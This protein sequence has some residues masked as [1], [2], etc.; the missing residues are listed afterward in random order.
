MRNLKIFAM[1]V[2]FVLALGISASAQVTV[3]GSTGANGSYANLG[4]AFTAI[5]GATQTGNN[6]TV[7]IT[8]NVTE[9]GPAVLNSGAW[10][11]LTI[12]PTADLLTISGATATGRGLIE[13]N[14]ADNVTIDGDN[15]GSGGTNRNLTI[16][17]TAA[18]TITY[19]SVIRLAVLASTQTS[20]DNVTIKNTILLGS[21]TGRNAVANTSTTGSE[22]TVFGIYAGGNGGATVPTAITSVTTNTAPSGTTVNNFNVTNNSINACARGV[23]FN[24]AA[25]S[26]SNGVTVSGNTIGD[27]STPTPATPPYTSPA[28]T[29]YTKGIW[30]AGAGAVTVTGNTINDVI[31]YVGTTISA[32][33]LNSVIGTSVTISSNTVTNTANNGTVSIVKAILVSSATGTY[34]IA[35]NIVTNVQAVAGTS[36]TS[37]IEVTSASLTGSVIERNKITTVYNRKDD[38]WGAWGLNLTGGTGITVRNN[39][40]SDLQSATGGSGTFSTTFGIFGLRIAGGTNHK[41]YHNSVNLFGPLLVGTGTNGTLTAAFAVT[42]TTVTGMDVRNNI[43]ANTLTSGNASTAHVSMFL[44]SSATSSMNLTINNNDYFSG[45]T[46]GQSG[47]AHVGTTYTAVPAGPATYAGLY[48]AANFNPADTANVLNLRTYTNT[49]NG[50]GTNDNASKVVDPLFVS[51]TDL[52]IAVAS[53]MV[54]MGAS[55]GVTNDIDSQLRVA[56]PDIGADEPSGI[57]PPANDIAA[58]AIL[59]PAPSSLVTTGTAPTPQASFTNAGTATQTSVS[60]QFTITGPGG[61]N[62]SN[63]QVIPSIAPNQTINVSFAAAPAITTAGTYN[64]TASVITPDANTAND[65]VAGTFSASAPLSGAISVGTGQ[66]YTSLTNPGGAFDALNGLGATS[67]VTLN[68]TSDLTAETGTISLN[69]LAGGFTVTIQPSGG[70]ARVISGSNTTAL[71]NLNGADGVLFNGLNTAG[72]SLLIRNTSATSG[73]VIRFINDASFNTI[74]NCTIESGTTGTTI[75]I[76]TGTTTGNDNNTITTN[77]IRDRSDVAGVALSGITSSGT[78]AA[79]AN[80]NT[81]ITNNQITNFTGSG[82]VITTG[83]ENVTITGNDIS[84]TATRSTAQIGIQMS[85]S[86]GTNLVSQNQIHGLRTTFAAGTGISTAGIFFGDARATTVS[87]NRIYDFP[88]AAGGTGRLSGIESDGG[89]G[90]AASVTIVNNMVSISPTVS[91]NQAIF[92]IFD[93]GFGG[94]TFIADFNSVYI[95]G[96]ASGTAA[97]WALVRGTLAPTAFTARNN[98]AFNNRTGGGANHFA[99]GDQSANTGTFVADR[100]FYA[101]TGTT[102]ANFFDYGTSGAGTPVSFTTW[103]AGPPTRDAN[104]TA[105]IAANYTIANIFVDAAAGNLHILGTATQVIG[106]GISIAGI[107]NDYDNDLRDSA[108]DI[109]ADELVAGFS[110]T[111]PAGT[112]RDAFLNNGTTL[113]GNVTITGTLT[114]GGV[115]NA[116]GNNLTIACGASIS[117]A[118]SGAYVYGGTIVKDFC[119]T[120]SFT[121]PVGSS[122]A[123]RNSDES[124]GGNN[125]YTPVTANVT[126]LGINPSSLAVSVTNNFMAGVDTSNA[127]DRYWT[128]TETGD[129]TANLSF[130]Y[131]D[132]DVNGNEALYKVLRRSGGVTVSSPSSTVVAATNTATINNVS[133]FSDWSVGLPLVVAANVNIGGRILMADEVTGI[134][135][136]R[137]ILTGGNLTQPLIARTNPFGYYN[138]DD[139]QVGQTYIL[140]VNSRNYTFQL[141][142]RVITAVDSITDADFIANP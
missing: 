132:G 56:A 85:V 127:I 51:N 23:V 130:V 16:Q 128:L 19:T 117:G 53:P 103:K 111:V 76:S 102:A 59:V 93:F 5:N 61:Y 67:N 139:L 94:N 60:V 10:T 47:I 36:G 39:F 136:V 25:A 40:I 20:A 66:T 12:R 33:E 49:L 119:T 29:V 131:D 137:V 90:T 1:L 68:I 124:F 3:G 42:A 28:T 96:T 123:L 86:L 100:N 27:T 18:N 45:S 114:L 6:I 99:G 35:D 125:A 37:G 88:G 141:P 55:V 44:P 63:T 112:Y 138:F 110:G 115:I 121:Y 72:N 22:N 26:V 69:Q 104:S 78:S 133:T 57:T 101:G 74:M 134:P 107:N 58:T 108:P 17:N 48:T 91:I 70:A 73:S 97:T 84:S 15:A 50:A 140:T 9:T 135:R 89:N 120:G 64:T 71:I 95:G 7:D 46:A 21:A 30:L 79:I 142:T 38:T 118:G 92:G 126:A 14:G 62:Y 87:R 75:N 82:I 129:L 83:S 32:I 122:L 34:T 24:G 77:I 80:S 65:S 116:A 54:D 98:I 43:F 106:N 4:A 113:G 11:T 81:A 8:A 31:S 41:I 2:F 105:D 13:L 52:H 109:G